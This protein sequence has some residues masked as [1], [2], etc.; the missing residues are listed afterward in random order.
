MSLAG[1]E[2]TITASQR[3][4]TYALDRAATGIGNI[5]HYSLLILY[6]KY[7]LPIPAAIPPQVSAAGW[8]GYVNKISRQKRQT[9]FAR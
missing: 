7:R 8:V 1:F 3:L 5:Q 9:I 6:D 4:H 2:P